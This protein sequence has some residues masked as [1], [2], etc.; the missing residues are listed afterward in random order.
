MYYVLLA[1]AFCGSTALAAEG[2]SELFN[3][4]D[5]NGDEKLDFSEVQGNWVLSKDFRSFDKNRDGLLDSAEFAA[6]TPAGGNNAPRAPGQ[7]S[8][9]APSGNQ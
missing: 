4:L 5:R 8:V 9:R 6:S 2:G 7:T 3:S 1:I